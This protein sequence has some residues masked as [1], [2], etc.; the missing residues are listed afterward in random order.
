MNILK[1]AANGTPI[2]D[3]CRE[4]GMSNETFYKWRAKYDGMD[5]S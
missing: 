2:H 3:F 4:R 1:Q 5:A